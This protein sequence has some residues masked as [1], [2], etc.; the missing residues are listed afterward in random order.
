MADEAPQVKKDVVPST[1]RDKYKATGGHAGDF[2]GAELQK[3]GK[4]GEA[5]LKAVM[6]ENNIPVSRWAGHNF[7]MQRMNL[8]NV[9][10]ST[11]LNGGTIYLLGK[12]YDVNHMREDYNGELAEDKPATI[13]KF[14]EVNNLQTNDRT[15]KA[16]TKTFFEGARKAKALEEREAK[17][18]ADA[19]AKAKKEAD[20]AAAAK[21]KA[22]DK[23]AADAKKAEEK[24][25]KE[26]KAKADKEAAAKAKADKAAA[27]KAAKDAKAKEPAKADA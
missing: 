20:K 1:Y 15:V 3:I 12:Q 6:K 19:E 5:A 8:A 17:K 11:L 24:A 10:R 27:D 21:K 14:A 9:L 2:I 26:A 22:D 4:D 25:A 16:L 13:R 18:K 7:G 23:A